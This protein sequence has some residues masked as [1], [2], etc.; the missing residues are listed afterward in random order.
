MAD[1]LAELWVV[2]PA[3]VAAVTVHEAGHAL[4]AALFGDP[5]AREGGR[6]SLNPLRHC[7]L[8]GTALVPIS[9]FVVT[10]LMA[11]PLTLAGWGKA[12]PI[13]EDLT[14]RKVGLLCTALAGP[15]ANLMLAALCIGLLGHVQGS[16]GMNTFLQTCVSFNLFLCVVNLL[17]VMPL[18]GATCIRALSSDRLWNE[19]QQIQPCLYVIGAGLLLTGLLNKYMVWATQGLLNVL[20]GGVI[21]G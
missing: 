15:M 21:Y 12:V 17:P 8:L 18:D 6:V 19:Y 10:S 14:V 16:A 4:V 3:L 20:L 9:V 13:S 11:L 2:F 5:A 7:S 1:G